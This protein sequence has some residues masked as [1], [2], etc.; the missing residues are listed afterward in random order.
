MPTKKLTFLGLQE[1]SVLNPL[2]TNACSNC[3]DNCYD[4]NTDNDHGAG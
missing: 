1:D 2:D 4:C 3:D